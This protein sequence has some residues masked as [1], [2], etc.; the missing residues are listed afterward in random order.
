MPEALV[1]AAD[2][3]EH[4]AAEASV[5]RGGIR[6]DRLLAS[7][8]LGRGAKRADPIMRPLRADAATYTAE[9]LV[10]AV[11]HGRELLQ[12]VG[13]RCAVVVKESHEGGLRRGYA[14]V[15]RSGRAR[16]V[17]SQ[18]ADTMPLSDGLVRGAVVRHRTV[19]DHDRLK[20]LVCDGAKSA[21]RAIQQLTAIIGRHDD[22]DRRGHAPQA[23][24]S[25][26]ASSLPYPLWSSKSRSGGGRETPERRSVLRE[27]PLCADIGA[28]RPLRSSRAGETGSNP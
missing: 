27:Q 15:S 26:A 3:I 24:A 9:R 2:L 17:L 12:P 4:S 28:R 21:E 14:A 18:I 25:R 20:R 7:A 16:V 13:G 23:N 6:E 5:R 10:V 11:E 8:V 22:G 19:I 1:K